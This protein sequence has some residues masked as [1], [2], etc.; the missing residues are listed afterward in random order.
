M[1]EIIELT[2]LLMIK[3]MILFKSSASRYSVGSI[4]SITGALLAAMR[5]VPPLIGSNYMSSVLRRGD[6]K[7]SGEC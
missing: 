4:S 7:R 2:L 1:K 3:R 5:L 6:P